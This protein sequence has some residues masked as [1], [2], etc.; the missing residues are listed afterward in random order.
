MAQVHE[1]QGTEFFS[2]HPLPK[3]RAEK[4]KEWMP[5][6]MRIYESGECAELVEFSVAAFR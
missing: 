3:N 4:L 6:A 5:E 2:T 1:G